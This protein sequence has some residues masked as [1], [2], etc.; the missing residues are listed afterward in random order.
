MEHQSATVLIEDEKVLS[1]VRHLIDNERIVR[2]YICAYEMNIC[3]IASTHNCVETDFI[4]IN[5]TDLGQSIK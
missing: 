4:V 2:R 5:K 3:T 1:T